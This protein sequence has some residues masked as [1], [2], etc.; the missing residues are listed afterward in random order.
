MLPYW[1][2]F[3]LPVIGAFSSIKL[4]RRSHLLVWLAVW[5]FYTLVVGLRYEVGGDW[6]AYLHHFNWRSD[7]NLSQALTSGDPGYY[8]LN[9]VVA[10]LGGSIFWVNLICAGMLM[11]GIVVFCRIQPAPWVAFAVAV[12]YLIIVVGMGYT[13][14]ATALGLLMLALVVLSKE[15]LLWFVIW[16]MIA[17]TFHKSAVL[18]LPIAA[19]ASTGNRL[20]SAF[21]V[22]LISLL[23][24]YLFVF[25]TADTLWTNYVEADYQSRGGLIRVLMNSV[26]ALVFLLLH[27]R[28]DLT[29]A[30]TR[31]WW[32]MSIFALVCIPLVL[33]SST[34]TDRVAL[35]LIP[36]QLFVL[37]RL[38]LISKKPIMRAFIICAV[39]GYFAAV[40]AV[41]LLFA[42]HSSAWLP[43]QM[44]WFLPDQ[45][46]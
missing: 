6:A 21:W 33:L 27:K 7:M 2:F 25:D 40:L 30:Q 42:V 19:L 22:G 45:S 34:A 24:A 41:W 43:Y 18:M 39:I 37:G 3:I 10:E 20:W 12:P 13:R 11:A 31:L 35:Y 8:A 26:P 17:A 5:L 14:Q 38:H 28:L 1:L 29:R 9:W 36:L 23:G 32:W 44:I 4:N 15:R 46:F 16:V